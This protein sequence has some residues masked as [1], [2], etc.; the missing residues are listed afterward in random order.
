MSNTL[1]DLFNNN[2]DVEIIEVMGYEDCQLL[3]LSSKGRK[4][5]IFDNDLACR[6]AELPDATSVSG[7][8]T[9]E[10]YN[11]YANYNIIQASHR[12]CVYRLG[13]EQRSLE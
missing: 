10:G 8:I 5:R 4:L 9:A 7:H 11:I 3:G 1:T 13:R 2:P 6:L 12:V